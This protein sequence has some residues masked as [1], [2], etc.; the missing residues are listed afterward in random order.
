MLVLGSLLKLWLR[1]YILS[2]VSGCCSQLLD[3]HCLIFN[4]LLLTLQGFN[5]LMADYRQ[6]G[7]VEVL[8]LSN[9]ATLECSRQDFSSSSAQQI[10]F[11]LVSRRETSWCILLN[12]LNSFHRRG[13]NIFCKV[14]S[15]GCILVALVSHTF[16][17]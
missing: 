9:E 13:S 12:F 7:L 15:E 6:E 1:L 2:S 17:C 10:A 11:S 4:N 5:H 14:N 16:L 3:V 8:V